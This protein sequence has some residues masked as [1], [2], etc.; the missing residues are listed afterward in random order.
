MPFVIATV[1]RARRP[2]S[3]RPGDSAIVLGDGTIEGFVGGVCAE[4]TVRLYS[5]RVLETGEPLLLRLVP[6]DGGRRTADDPI[7]GAIVEHNPCLSGGSLEIFLEPQLPAARI[8][9]VGSAPIALALAKLGGAADYDVIHATAGDDI[10]PGAGR[11]RGDRRLARQR[12][13]ARASEALTPGVPYVALV[14]S[15]TRGTAVR[16]ALEVPDELR[17][18]LH[19]PAGLDIGARTPTEIAI[20]I[21]AEVVAEHHAARPRRRRRPR[22]RSTRMRHAGRGHRLH[23]AAG[24]SMAYARVLLR[25]PLPRHVRGAAR[26]P[27]RRAR[28]VRHGPRAGRR[29]LDATRPAQAAAPLRRRDAARPRARRRPRVPVSTSGCA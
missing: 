6:G 13:G 19:T 7:D 18:Q 24:C 10:H 4:S 21:L 23:A 1:V 12:R 11:R 25:R 29:R 26:R 20:S 9:I 28:P 22:P 5:L 27:W 15:R 14:A 8:V 17:A 16:D 3:V 2:T